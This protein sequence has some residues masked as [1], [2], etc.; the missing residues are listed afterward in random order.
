MS[1]IRSILE[2]LLVD[3]H[4]DRL[5]CETSEFEKCDKYNI[6][7]ALKEIEQ[8]VRSKRD[9]LRGYPNVDA[10]IDEFVKELLK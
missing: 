7:Q 2:E 8:V 1:S 10:L 4:N 3:N 9:R 5:S 6:D